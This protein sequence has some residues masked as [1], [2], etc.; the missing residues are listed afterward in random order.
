MHHFTE[1]DGVLHAEDVALPVIADAVGTPVYVYAAATLRRHYQVFA[2]AFA[3]TNT[4]IAYSVKANSNLAVVRT[5]AKLGA[6][7]DVVSGGEL[8]RAITAGIPAEKIVFAGVGKAE[9]ELNAALDVGIGL[10][11]VESEPELERL[12]KLATAKGVA[13]R[14]ALR[15][16]PDVVAGGHAKIS[17][18]KAEDKFGVSW[19]QAAKL[20]ARAA[21]MPGVTPV[22]LDA[23]IGSQIVDV[24]PFAQAAERL[25]ELTNDLRANGFTVELIDMGGGLGIPY[26]EGRDAPALPANYAQAV[27]DHLRPL[28]VQV[29]IEPGR[30]IAGNAGVL[31]TRVEYVKVG[32]ARTFVVVDAGMND[33]LR[34]ALYDAFHDIR[35]VR[36]KAS[37]PTAAPVA[38]VGPVCETGD[39]FAAARDL[40][41]VDEGDLLVIHSAGA[42]GAVQASEYN[43]RPRIA[44]VL[45]DGDQWAVV[46]RRN[47]IEAMLAAESIP[48]WI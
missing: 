29:I 36:T 6:G 35:A 12:S 27:L 23:H 14:I 37:A 5:L 21:A 3:G 9:A 7:A 4:L 19:G 41:A 20:Y 47:T 42:Y 10:F 45:V 16:N 38:V 15:V 31:L 17:T 22:G 25:A 34:P 24:A 32:D 33:L 28:D 8:T 39:T 46:R 30:L 48:D 18:G 13:A 40:P 26:G 44:E 43:S 11:N 1:R 2:E